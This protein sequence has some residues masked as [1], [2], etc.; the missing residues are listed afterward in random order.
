[1]SRVAAVNERYRATAAVA[2]DGVSLF[3]VADENGA[4]LNAAIGAVARMAAED[5][6][7]LWEHVLGAAKSLRWHLAFRPQPLE[8]NPSV[9]TAAHA[10]VAQADAIRPALGDDGTALLDALTEAAERVAAEDPPI[11]PYLLESVVEVGPAACLVVADGTLSRGQIASWLGP[12]GFRVLSPGMLADATSIADVAYVVGPPRLMRTSLATAPPTPEVSFFVPSWFGDRSLPT[13][14]IADYAQGA[15]RPRVRVFELGKLKPNADEVAPEPEPIEDFAPAPVWKSQS[16]AHRVPGV[17][18]VVVRKVLLSGGYAIW[19]DDGERIRTLDPSQPTGERVTYTDVA[20]V[21]PGT[22]LVLRLGVTERTVL[23][24]ATMASMGVLRAVVE[25]SQDRW[26]QALLGRLRSAGRPHVES[27]IRRLGVKAAEQAEAWTQPTLAR[28]QLDSDFKLLLQWLEI[29]EEPT[30]SNATKFR[31][32]RFRAAS[33]M[34][35]QL[36]LAMASADIEALRVEGHVKV[37]G[38]G[39]A[40]IIATRVLAISPHTNVVP[41]HDA[42]EPFLDGGGRWLE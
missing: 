14:A 5:G 40:D 12:L 22:Y 30:L 27:A 34:R 29:A 20:A 7:D 18:E 26:K 42:R 15:I 36:E 2:R 17:D 9:T 19:M 28:P 1:M 32:A 11:G 8:F 24:E 39:F 3:V 4:T 21:E 38:A 33:H 35:E 31:R 16:S 37:H 23:Y 41:R 6:S 25:S 10:V 13:T